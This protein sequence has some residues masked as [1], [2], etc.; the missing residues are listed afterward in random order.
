MIKGKYNSKDNDY[1]I[2]QLHI[3]QLLKD[4]KLF[5]EYD[6]KIGYIDLLFKQVQIKN[7][8]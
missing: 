4:A 2:T 1:Y 5:T 3:N 6:I 8:F 7:K